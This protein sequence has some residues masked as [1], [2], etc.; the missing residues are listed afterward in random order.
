MNINVDVILEKNEPQQQAVI[1]IEM[2]IRTTNMIIEI[3]AKHMNVN[4]EYA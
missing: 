1:L 2:D 3:A 4:R